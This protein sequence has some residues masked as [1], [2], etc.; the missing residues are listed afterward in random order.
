MQND[1]TATHSGKRYDVL[2]DN[3][4][5]LES[6][7]SWALAARHLRLWQTDD[8]TGS[9]R[10]NGEGIDLDEYERRE[11]SGERS[12][13]TDFVLT[14]RMPH[15]DGEAEIVARVTTRHH[16]KAEYV[17]RPDKCFKTGIQKVTLVYNNGRLRSWQTDLYSGVGLHTQPTPRFNVKA[18]KAA[19]ERALEAL[20]DNLDHPQ[21]IE[22]FTVKEYA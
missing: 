1:L 10:D 11:D 13:T 21:V 3:G 9:I 19:H 5:T 6:F 7:D 16:G 4:D 22:Q 12:L 14:D 17:G 20:A 8:A 2:D 15:R 18:L